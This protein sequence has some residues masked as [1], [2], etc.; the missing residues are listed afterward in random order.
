MDWNNYRKEI[1]SADFDPDFSQRAARQVEAMWQERKEPYYMKKTGKS[2]RLALI[3]ACLTVLMSVTAAAAVIVTSFRQTAREDLGIQAENPIPEYTEYAEERSE[4]NGMK[5]VSTVCSGTRMDAIFAM[6]HVPA[7][8]GSIIDQGKGYEWDLGGI[9]TSDSNGASTTSLLKQIDYNSDSETA[10][11]RLTL[12]SDTLPNQDTISVSLFLRSPAEDVLFGS[13]D[14]PVTKSQTLTAPTN[15]T[16][17][18]GQVTGISIGAGFIEVS[19]DADPITA[20]EIE[21]IDAEVSGRLETI[22]ASLDTMTLQFEDGTET[23]VT[24]LPSP[25]AAAWMLA[26]ESIHDMEQGQFR[27][28]HICEQMLDIQTVVSVT[29]DGNVIKLR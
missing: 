13:I 29:I 18:C 8:I 20:K 22:N 5:L 11:V 25:L 2:F 28:Q 17:P 3:A 7:E 1:D 12:L 23:K 9:H 24:E 27:M 15:L 14:I 10:L 19:I 4:E 16:L 21:V 6:S 26:G